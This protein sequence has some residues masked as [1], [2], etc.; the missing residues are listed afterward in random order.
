MRGYAHEKSTTRRRR[1]GGG[2]NGGCGGQRKLDETQTKRQNAE[3]GLSTG[4]ASSGAWDV[5]RRGGENRVRCRRA[6]NEKWE[7]VCT[8]RATTRWCARPVHMAFARTSGVSLRRCRRVHVGVG[9]RGCTSVCAGVRCDTHTG[10][11]TSTSTSTSTRRRRED[12]GYEGEERH[13]ESKRN[14]RN[15]SPPRNRD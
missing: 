12:G 5:R 8:E 9:G 10:T 11:H 14:R 4:R 7:S 13:G 6:A 1:V 2:D 15:E 3:K